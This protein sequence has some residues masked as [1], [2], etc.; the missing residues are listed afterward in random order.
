ML[1]T[2]QSSPNAWSVP[3]FIP[4]RLDDFAVKE[5]IAHS[6]ALPT[7]EKYRGR[8]LQYNIRLNDMS[9][10]VITDRLTMWQYCGY[11]I[12]SMYRD[13]VVHKSLGRSASFPVRCGSKIGLL[14]SN[15][16]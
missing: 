5:C 6:A 3:L 1:L 13:T 12:A 16:H 2:L 15:K 8:W 10:A 11:N 7:A 9:N 4:F 14:S